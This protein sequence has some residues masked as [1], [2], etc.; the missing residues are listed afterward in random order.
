MKLL[1]RKDL[2]DPWGRR[3][4]YVVE[5]KWGDGTWSPID[6]GYRRY[7]D[8]VEAKNEEI[9]YLPE[10]DSRENFRIATYVRAEE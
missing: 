8:A 4:L 10:I 6:K 3:T 2:K 1:T 5:F 7:S 9:N